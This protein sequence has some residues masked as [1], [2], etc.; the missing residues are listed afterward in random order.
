METPKKAVNI[1]GCTRSG[2]CGLVKPGR[3]RREGRLLRAEGRFGG[4]Y[5][6][7]ERIEN[8]LAGGIFIGGGIVSADCGEEFRGNGNY[9]EM[10]GKNE[11]KR[12]EGKL[13]LLRVWI[14]VWCYCA[15]LA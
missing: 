5:R 8:V 9:G 10:Q 4:H 7:H 12:G 3:L 6:I 14:P 2:E 1:C 13:G 15:V 11:Q